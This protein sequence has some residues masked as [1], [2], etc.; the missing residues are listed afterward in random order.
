MILFDKYVFMEPFQRSN[1]YI[2]F[3]LGVSYLRYAN[4]YLENISETGKRNGKQIYTSINYRKKMHIPNMKLLFHSGKFEIRMT[5]LSIFRFY[6]KAGS[7]PAKIFVF[8]KI[9]FENRRML[10]QVLKFDNGFY[11]EY[12]GTAIKIKL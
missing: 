3:L 2:K 9:T 4:K 7:R 6:T 8:M 11:I 12:F 10:Q 5:E 1:Q